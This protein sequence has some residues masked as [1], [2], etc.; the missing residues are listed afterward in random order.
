MFLLLTTLN[1]VGLIQVAQKQ[2]SVVFEG[3]VK[4]VLKELERE[5][6]YRNLRLD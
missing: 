2:A 1:S 3:V 6:K 4:E 5:N